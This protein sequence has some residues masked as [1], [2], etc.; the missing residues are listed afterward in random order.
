MMK[1]V[2]LCCE[3]L[4]GMSTYFVPI[5][6][7]REEKYGLLSI[8]QLGIVPPFVQTPKRPRTGCSGHGQFSKFSEFPEVGVSEFLDFRLHFES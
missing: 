5:V 3:V 4:E 6:F 1:S 8:R 2:R 7:Q